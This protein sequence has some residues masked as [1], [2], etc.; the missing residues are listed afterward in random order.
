MLM[1]DLIGDIHG[2]ADELERLLDALGY[3]KTGG[4]YGHPGNRWQA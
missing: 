1:F 3:R 4:V 2:H